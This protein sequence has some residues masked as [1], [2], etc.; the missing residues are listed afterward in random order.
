MILLAL[1]RYL[2]RTEWGINELPG[3]SLKFMEG[4]ISVERAGTNH[5]QKIMYSLLQRG[6]H[7]YMTTSPQVLPI[8]GEIKLDM[9]KNH[10]KLTSTIK[11]E[12]SYTLIR[13]QLK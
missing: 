5:K 12:V 3:Y 4:H 9:I 6:D 1:R 7:C 2:E 10:I 13:E 11:P 8:P